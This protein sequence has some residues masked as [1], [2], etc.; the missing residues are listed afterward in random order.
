M[1]KL[2]K[3]PKC[4][5][6]ARIETDWEHN[7]PVTNSFLYIVKCTDCGIVSKS[8]RTREEAA[9]GWKRAIS[10]TW[11]GETIDSCLWK[12]GNCFRTEEEAKT[13]GKE[14]MEQIQKEF[15]ES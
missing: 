6:T 9:F 14:I 11:E 12:C 4:K 1:I 10:L 7:D 13:K 5:G 8:M 15:E 3:C 2:R